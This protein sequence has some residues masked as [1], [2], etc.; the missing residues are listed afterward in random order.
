MKLL[1]LLLLSTS[2]FAQFTALPPLPPV[3]NAITTK[4]GLLTSNG[5]AQVE[6]LAC[7]DDEIIVYDSTEANGFK[8][9]TVSGGGAS[10]LQDVALSSTS[11]TGTVTA[12]TFAPITLGAG[13]VVN[14]N[15][16]ASPLINN[17]SALW[18]YGTAAICTYQLLRNGTLIQAAG[19]DNATATS[20]GGFHF[21]DFPPA[22]TYTYSFVLRVSLGSG[23]CGFNFPNVKSRMYV[24]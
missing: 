16:Y 24:L 10:D 3:E 20:S 11:T 21:T 13:K 18:Y 9:S 22:G 4:G 17:N 7:A 6:A 14:F 15:H 19:F 23:T 8:C 1:L 2:A 5:T 12:V